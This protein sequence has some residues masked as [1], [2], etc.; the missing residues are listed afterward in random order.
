[1]STIN[2]DIIKGLKR[3]IE[4]AEEKIEELKKPS[5]KSAAHMRAA[6]RDFWRKK[7]EELKQKVKELEDEC[8]AID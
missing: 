1:M 8:T 2:Q 4:V 7:S 3:S 6:E 5:Q